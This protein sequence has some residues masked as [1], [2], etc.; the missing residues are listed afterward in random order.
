MKKVFLAMAVLAILF[1]GCNKENN[2]IENLDQKIVG[3]WMMT[4][5][6]G[7]PL[8]T[9]ERMVYTFESATKAYVS[10]S[11]TTHPETGTYWNDQLESDVAI[12]GNKMT[13]TN[14]PTEHT[15][16]V[17]EYTVT[18][19]SDSD[20]TANYKVT[21]TIDGNVAGNE[22]MVLRFVKVKANYK[23]AVVGF[24]ECKEL[25][26][27]ETFNDVDARLVFFTDGTYKYWNKDA[28]GQWQAVT[29]REFQDYFVDGTLLATRWKNVGEEELREWWE[30][31]SISEDQMVWTALRQNSDGT[32][33]QQG[34]KWKKVK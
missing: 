16:V 8:P 5:K 23:A 22:T 24:W 14:H 7:Q 18:A 10:A 9:N 19:I 25:T 33:V 12:S 20:F 31:A 6:N 1:S 13:L 27:V 30:I 28:D 17:E 4:D 2:T 15:T 34:A 3:K 26:G 11:I 32:T 21:V 29:T